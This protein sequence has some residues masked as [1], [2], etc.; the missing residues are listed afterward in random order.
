M[1]LFATVRKRSEQLICSSTSRRGSS[2]H[3]LVISA[4]VPVWEG[5]AT[6]PIL[7]GETALA[8]HLSKES[9]VFYLENGIVESA[10]DKVNP[11]VGDGPPS[12]VYCPLSA[13]L[14]Q[15]RGTCWLICRHHHFKNLRHIPAWGPLY[16][17]S[18]ETV[19][20]SR[21]V[22]VMFLRSWDSTCIYLPR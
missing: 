13:R 9:I 10:S 8:H 11:C 12:K 22:F 15:I 7:A 5:A 6:D 3:G 16:Q 14:S 17:N 19:I 18:S 2:S 4:K 21:M 20:L 1:K